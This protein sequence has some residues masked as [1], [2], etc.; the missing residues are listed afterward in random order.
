VVWGLVRSASVG[1]GS[2]EV[3]LSLLV[4]VL[5]IVAFVGWE[6]RARTPMLPMRLF[7]SAAFAAPNA[8]GF[9]LTAS[10]FGAVYFLAQFLQTAQGYGPLSAGLRLLPWTGTLFIVAP[11]AG[12]LVNRFGERLFTVGGLLLQAAGMGWIAL[13]ASPHVGFAATVPPL[14]LAGVGVSMVFPAVQNAVVGS[15]RPEAIGKA[16]GTY[17]MLRQLGGVFGIAILVAVFTARGS[18]VTGQRFSDGFAP[19]IGVSAALSFLG[20]LA[21]LGIS[22]R[23]A[24]SV[25]ASGPVTEALPAEV[26]K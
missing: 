11:I 3:V 24:V 21:G 6:M 14:V 20:A 16:S 19:A 25:L 26:G 1:W 4:G 17:N 23:P 7:R 22:R 12:S 8:A 9:F 2:A 10:L 15:V 5:V 13:I 18:Y